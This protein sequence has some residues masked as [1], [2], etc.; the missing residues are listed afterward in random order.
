MSGYIEPERLQL[1]KEGWLSGVTH[2]P[3][4]NCNARPASAVVSL[5]VIHNISLPPGEYGGGHIAELFT[6]Q[7]DKDTHPYFASVAELQVSSHFLI[8]RDGSLTQFVGTQQRAWHAGI[9]SFQG[10]QNCN[11]FSVGIELE[12]CDE[13]PYNDAQYAALA[14]LTV[15]L[16]NRYPALTSQRIV[17]HC[18]IAPGRKTDPGPSFDWP[19]YFK[20]L[21]TSS[22]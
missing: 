11:D 10:V 17:G 3:S 2:C 20:L 4:P 14:A 9:S 6:N 8:E 19:R 18:D 21:G 5:L 13:S 22:R 15:L 1:S 7:L 12:G 16:L